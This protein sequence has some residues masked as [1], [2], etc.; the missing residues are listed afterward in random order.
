VTCYRFLGF[1]GAESGTKQVKRCFTIGQNACHPV[2]PPL[3][4]E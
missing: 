1:A 4:S 3:L 2:R